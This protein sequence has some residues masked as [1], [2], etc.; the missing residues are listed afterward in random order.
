M[1]IA[2]NMARREIAYKHPSVNVV[3]NLVHIEIPVG[4]CHISTVDM[5][6]TDKTD[7]DI[8]LL[9]RSIIGG[10]PPAN[11]RQKLFD[12]ILM[13]PVADVIPEEVAKLAACISPTDKKKYKYIKGMY[14]QVHHN[15]F[16]NAPVIKT[17]SPPC[18]PAYIPKKTAM[19]DID[20]ADIVV[21]PNEP[22][23]ATRTDSSDRPK[24]GSTTGK[25]WEIADN[26]K[27]T[28]QFADKKA[29]RKAVIEACIQAGINNSTASVQFGKWHSTQ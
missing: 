19:D 16:E 15:P 24:A 22:K 12:H 18:P 9:Y 6:L 2:I 3:L 13:Y 21:V 7:L 28:G 4:E 11:A 5:C 14:G 27:S 25:V 20:E 17:P 26:I 8:K 10:E 23:A 29:L 1:Y